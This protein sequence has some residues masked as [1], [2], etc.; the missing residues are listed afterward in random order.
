MEFIKNINLKGKIVRV[1]RVGTIF[2]YI[3]ENHFSYI[4]TKTLPTLTT[5]KN[6]KESR[7]FK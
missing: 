1:V 3:C 5:N 4:S 7:M 6:L 2:L